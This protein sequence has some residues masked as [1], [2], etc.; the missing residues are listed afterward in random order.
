MKDPARF[1]FDAAHSGVYAAPVSV[2]ALRQGAHASGLAWF[3]LD[4]AGVTGKA[5]LLARCQT[6][7]GL[8]PSF[9]HNWDAL[10]DCLE[11]LS[12]HPARGFVVFASNGAELAKHAPRD[13]EVA[14]EILAAAS[15]YWLAKGQLFLVLLDA[16]TRGSRALKAL[17]G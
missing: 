3:D 7:F 2:V 16:E 14:L 8:P 10:T 17:P 11:D 5:G 15:I 13:F 6:V 4:L 12:W 1:P 9:G